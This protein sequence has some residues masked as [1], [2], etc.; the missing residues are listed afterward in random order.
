[1]HEID[2]SISVRTVALWRNEAIWRQHLKKSTRLVRWREN[3]PS[4]LEKRRWVLFLWYV[5]RFE[6][7]HE[8]SVASQGDSAQYHIRE[9]DR[10]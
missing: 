8:W 4:A 2:K 1:M 7:Y 10:S 9:P 6:S 5:T 3:T